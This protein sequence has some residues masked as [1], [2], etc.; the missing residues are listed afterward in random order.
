MNETRKLNY[1]TINK[2]MD[3]ANGGQSEYN[4]FDLNDMNKVAEEFD[5]KCVEYAEKNKN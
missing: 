2:I 1:S 3:G 5:R 4:G